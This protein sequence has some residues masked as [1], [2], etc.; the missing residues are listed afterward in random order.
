MVSALT[1]KK[2]YEARTL[3]ELDWDYTKEEATPLGATPG[4]RG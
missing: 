4:S 2:A 1:E 3:P